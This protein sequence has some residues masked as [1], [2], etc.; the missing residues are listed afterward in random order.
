MT[1]FK[2]FVPEID[3]ADLIYRAPDE[4]LVKT[5][6]EQNPKVQEQANKNKKMKNNQEGSNM[7]TGSKIA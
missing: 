3:Q 7:D 5:I 2:K 1:K 6:K 4:S